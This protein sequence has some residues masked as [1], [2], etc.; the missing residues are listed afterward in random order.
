LQ[1]TISD[2]IFNRKYLAL[3]GA[4]FLLL[5]LVINF[6]KTDRIPNEIISNEVKICYLQ[7]N[8]EIPVLIIEDT[9]EEDNDSEFYYD[10]FNFNHTLY[11]FLNNRFSIETTTYRYTQ[12]NHYFQSDL[13]PPLV[14]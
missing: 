4:F 7:A 9:N 11:S 8:F 3:A 1:Q 12:I 10:S 2:K 5:I 6:L 14:M 13:S